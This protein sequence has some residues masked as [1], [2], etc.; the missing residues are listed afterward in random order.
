MSSFTRSSASS[1]ASF[2]WGDGHRKDGHELC[3]GSDKRLILS[4]AASD[5]HLGLLLLELRGQHARKELDEKGKSQLQAC[6]EKRRVKKREKNLVR[7]VDFGLPL[8]IPLPGTMIKAENGT[9]RKMSPTV[10]T[11]WRRS[12]LDSWSP[13]STWR[14]KRHATRMSTQSSC[15]GRRR[16][17][18]MNKEESPGHTL[19]RTA[20]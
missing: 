1:L 7:T 8:I 10:R 18:K 16:G 14:S 2:N 11:N 6:K 17:R 20:H 4:Q 15:Q 5:V 19:R 12:R 3:V 9:R 13:L